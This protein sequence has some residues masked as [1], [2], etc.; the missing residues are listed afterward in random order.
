ML[1]AAFVTLA[2]LFGF[3]AVPV[4]AS[5]G[6]L[7]GASRANDAL[8]AADRAQDDLSSARR[9]KKKSVRKA[10]RRPAATRYRRAAPAPMRQAQPGEDVCRGDAIRLC[11]PVLGQG[12][13]A[14]LGCFKARANRLS[15]GCRALLVNYGQL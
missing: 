1:K 8:S 14:V 3:T 5:A 4:P 9:A 11:R 12:N 13:M 2:L 7:S 6:G 10:A 15:R